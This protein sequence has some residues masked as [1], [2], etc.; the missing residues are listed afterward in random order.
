MADWRYNLGTAIAGVGN[1]LGLPEW[2]IS[3]SVGGYTAPDVYTQQKIGYNIPG[4]T[5]GP[6]PVS[7]LVIPQP[8]STPP[9]ATPTQQTT[10]QQL[11][12]QQT[13]QTGGGGGDWYQYYQGW[14]RG[15]AERDFSVVFGGNVDALRRSRGIYSSDDYMEM[16][17]KAYQ[18][19]IAAL[20]EIESGAKASTQESLSKMMRDYESYLA[21]M[22]GEETNLRAGQTEQERLVAESGRSAVD[23]ARRMYNLTVQQARSRFGAGSSAGPAAMEIASQEFARQQGR[24]GQT[25]I[26]AQ[27]ALSLEAGRLNTYISQKKNDLLR[28]KN[29]SEA[30]VNANL[31]ATLD[32]IALRRGELESA[33]AAARVNA[34]NQARAELQSLNQGFYNT[35]AALALAAIQSGQ[36]VT[37][38]A[39]SPQEQASIWNN[40]FAQQLTG[41]GPAVAPSVLAQ[42]FVPSNRRDQFGNL[43]QP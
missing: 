26:N 6:V 33:K 20:G 23:E 42:P 37:G 36:Q 39:F 35:R 34:I 11:P 27:Q 8:T 17:E 4:S 21:D 30:Q 24:L 13:Q 16:A 43:I 22:A 28:W 25:A 29:E 5:Y 19:A 10:S 2:G 7:Q 32:N 14:D 3:E 31:K 41:V 12:T 38:R 18:P 40:M 15:A 1:K 9:Q